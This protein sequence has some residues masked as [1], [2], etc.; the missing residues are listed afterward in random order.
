MPPM[1]VISSTLLDS[2][3]PSLPAVMISSFSAARPPA[4]PANTP[5]R[6][7]TSQRMRAGS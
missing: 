5:L 2:S 6:M 4:T 7:N 3:A 1:K